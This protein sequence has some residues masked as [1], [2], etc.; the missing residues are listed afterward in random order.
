MT[1]MLYSIKQLTD[2]AL[3][4]LEIERN[5]ISNKPDAEIVAH[6]RKQ[7]KKLALTHHPDRGGNISRFQLL[8]NAYEE[9]IASTDENSNELTQYFEQKHIEISLKAFNLVMEEEIE[10]INTALRQ[11]FSSLP[12]EQ[13]KEQFAKKHANF[14]NLVQTLENNKKKIQQARIDALMQQ[15]HD[16]SMKQ[17]YIN[18]VIEWRKQIITLFG[19]EG[20]N[21]FQY[22]EA[23]AFGNLWPILN[24]YKLM[25]PTKWLAAII[26][27]IALCLLHIDNALPY[28]IFGNQPS[29][30]AL[31]VYKLITFFIL[32]SFL[33]T[34]AVFLVFGAPT[35]Q[36]FLLLLACPHNLII[37]PLQERFSEQPKFLITIGVA[38]FALLASAAT[39]FIF[40]T[41]PPEMLIALVQITL[42]FWSMFQNYV[43]II[44]DKEL[45]GQ[46]NYHFI[47]LLLT[48]TIF[49]VLSIIVATLS[50]FSSM[51]AMMHHLP[52]PTTE[53]LWEDQ[54]FDFLMN[55]NMSQIITNLQFYKNF[56]AN[57]TEQLPLP[58][59]PS[60][61]EVKNIYIS[62]NTRATQS[63]YFF[64]TPKD[65]RPKNIPPRESFVPE[66]ETHLIA[67]IAN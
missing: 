47:K 15:E 11:E 34:P 40:T 19:E 64:K 66:E 56:V 35:I 61:D 26:G 27:S 37:R 43:F 67:D 23:L 25:L 2:E 8:K 18:F 28:L 24:T 30:N 20:L 5:D 39:F 59:E 60:T 13:H 54:I 50:L 29:Y 63:H 16:H 53:L 46:Y 12:N 14:F 42:Q 44:T 7:Y 55:C 57:I 1:D 10:H 21:D 65:V 22:R 49:S 3:Q 38:L 17:I 45:N 52:Q 48:S 33:P 6:I 58:E 31:I 32:I 9:L 51:H 4:T 62:E 41:I 36:K